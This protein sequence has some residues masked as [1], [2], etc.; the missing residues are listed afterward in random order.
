MIAP[1]K[2]SGLIKDQTL[3]LPYGVEDLDPDVVVASKAPTRVRCYV[4]GCSHFLNTPRR[5]FKGDVCPEHGIR[6]H[7]SSAGATYSY[8][9]V[10]RNI[11]ASSETFATKVVGHP[12]KYESHRLGLEKSEDT[13]SWNVFR[14]FHEAAE[15]KR[16]GE[17]ITGIRSEVEPALYLWGVCCSDDDFDPWHL[18]IAARKRFESHLPVDRPKTEPD[19]A[20]H[21]PG[22][23]LVLIEAK[24]TSPNTYYE[25]GPR[26]NNSSLTLDELLQIYSD[27]SLR[28]L[29]MQV[30]SRANRVY[31]QLWRNT[32]FAEYM[33][34]LDHANTKAF[35]VNLVR[36][37]SDRESAQEFGTMMSSAFASR[38]QQW[39]WEELYRLS[40]G[41]RR[42]GHLQRY[43]KTKTAGLRPAFRLSAQ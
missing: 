32:I 36:E 4:R 30:A 26:K 17:M 28:L 3:G 34:R 20:L 31:Y 19:I 6:C 9:D 16:L 22:K 25:R 29:N 43:M 14:S 2:T 10:R 15:L 24:F 40:N 39:T 21:L 41:Q 37:G 42:L 12:F 35:H 7:H 23:Y 1:M 27:P 5:G 18:L 8:V 13:V 33:S 38:F 11:I